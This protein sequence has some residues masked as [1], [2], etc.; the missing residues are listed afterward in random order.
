MAPADR[1]WLAGACLLASAGIAVASQPG[2]DAELLEFLA[3]WGDAGEWLD[4][5][6]GTDEADPRL[7][8]R[9]VEKD[10]EKDGRK[11]DD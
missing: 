4:A 11:R 3:D 6:L 10:S 5:E 7:Q 2:P 9:D 1:W 8:S